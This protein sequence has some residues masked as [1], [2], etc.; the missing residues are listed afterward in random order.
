SGK[1]R[2][3]K[4]TFTLIYLLFTSEIYNMNWMVASIQFIFHKKLQ[5]SI[6]ETL[7]KNNETSPQN[8][9]HSGEKM[10]IT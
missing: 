3:N 9:K 1:K 2:N 10:K 8:R 6:L 5:C 7:Q 4:I